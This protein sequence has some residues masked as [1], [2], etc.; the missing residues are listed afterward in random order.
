MTYFLKDCKTSRTLD[1][2]ELFEKYGVCSYWF[3]LL[4]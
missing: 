2:D 1:V 3:D 4:V